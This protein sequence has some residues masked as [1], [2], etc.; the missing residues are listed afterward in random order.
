MEVVLTSPSERIVLAN[1][2]V[3]IGRLASNWEFA[4]R[5]CD[6]WGNLYPN[7]TWCY[8]PSVH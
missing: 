4:V 5:R 2:P 3:A 1:A 7:I 6:T 8:C